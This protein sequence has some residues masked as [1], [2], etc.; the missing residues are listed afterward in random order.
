MTA[1]LLTLPRRSRTLA[2]GRLRA[3][4]R[5]TGLTQEAAALVIGK[6]PRQLRRWEK[7]EVDLGPLE[8]LC[9]L[10]ERARRAA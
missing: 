6:D 2:S 7:G 10:E 4:R 9:L 3:A 5:A 1:K 8:A